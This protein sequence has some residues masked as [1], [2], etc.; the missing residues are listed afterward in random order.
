MRGYSP[1][2]NARSLGPLPPLP[3]HTLYKGCLPAPSDLFFLS[4][5]PSLQS[6]LSLILFNSVTSYL[7]LSSLTL[8]LQTLTVTMHG[9]KVFAMVAL[10]CVVAALDGMIFYIYLWYIVP[11]L[12][13]SP[14]TCTLPTTVT[15]TVKEC[16]TATV[17]GPSSPMPPH[18]TPSVVQPVPPMSPTV[19]AP[20][21]VSA[22][23]EHPTTV[24]V[25]SNG[26]SV[27]VSESHS[28]T[29]SVPSSS[30]SKLPTSSTSSAPLTVS[31]A[32]AVAATAPAG[33]SH[34]VAAGALLNA[35]MILLV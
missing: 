20:S 33:L 7:L 1:P 6:L 28:G 9:F 13:T 10:A 12:L 8:S 5:L 29:T 19:P 30:G 16:I 15:V 17:P 14:G 25:P 2:A 27:H 35:G 31:T 11:Y 34:L 32:G 21:S 22:P 23:P 26:T 4:S 18:E 24:P 3:S